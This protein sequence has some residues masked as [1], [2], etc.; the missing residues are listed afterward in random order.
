MIDYWPTKKAFQ[1]GHK[2]LEGEKYVYEIF[3][4]KRNVWGQFFSF[5]FPE[6]GTRMAERYMYLARH[7]PLDAPPIFFCLSLTSLTFLIPLAGTLPLQEFL[8][9][10]GIEIDWGLDPKERRNKPAVAGFKKAVLELVASLRKAKA[11]NNAAPDR[12]KKDNTQP[13]PDESFDIEKAIENLDESFNQVE[14]LLTAIITRNDL[15][16]RERSKVRAKVRKYK[17]ILNAFLEATS[18]NQEDSG[19]KSP[20]SRRGK[21]GKADFSKRRPS[22]HPDH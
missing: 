12:A 3:G 18:E 21:G 9:E 8:A 7:I 22:R 13:E 15:E 5:Y 20:S 17:G 4:Q 1:I 11:N 14:Q 19:G 2:L 16:G 6:I 10:N